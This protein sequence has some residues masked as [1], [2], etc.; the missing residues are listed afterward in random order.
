MTELF[1]GTSAILVP[2]EL[3][4]GR[5]LLE[6]T[7]WSSSAAYYLG[8]GIW[9]A[10]TLVPWCACMGAMIPF[11][12]EA[13]KNLQ[14]RD[15]TGWAPRTSPGQ[16]SSGRSYSDRAFSYLY[17]ANVLGALAGA[18]VPPLLVELR[19]LHATLMIGAGLNGSLAMSALLLSM[20]V[21]DQEASATM[22]SDAAKV[23]GIPPMNRWPLVLLFGTGLTSMG[24]EVVW[25]RQFTPYVGTMVYSFA[26]ILAVYLSSTFLGSWFYRILEP[27]APSRKS[28]GTKMGL[29][30]VGMV[31][32]AAAVF[33]RSTDI[34]VDN[35]QGGVRSCAILSAVGFLDSNAGGPMGWRAIRT[36]QGEPMRST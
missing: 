29:G 6:R 11:A 5:L 33:R 21:R 3:L 18:I 35:Y 20:R 16:P 34:H 27:E 12:M 7:G 30:M 13:M 24:M 36:A 17:L 1:I 22:T 26:C 32:I 19:G 2:Q 4:W 15:A 28:T 9:I 31:G 25:I 14:A 23:S 10:L 8:S